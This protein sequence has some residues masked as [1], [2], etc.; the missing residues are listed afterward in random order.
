MSHRN[1]V[2]VFLYIGIV[3]ISAFANQVVSK[4]NE[5]MTL[6][7]YVTPASQ[8]QKADKIDLPI[9]ECNINEAET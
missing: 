4:S 1:I 8:P 9:S 6:G 3:S 5:G 7:T 2:L